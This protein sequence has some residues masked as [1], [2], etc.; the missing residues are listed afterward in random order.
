MAFCI[1]LDYGSGASWID[2]VSDAEYPAI[3]EDG[4]GFMFRL[5]SPGSQHENIRTACESASI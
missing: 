1:M 2:E 5:S 4:G 3:L